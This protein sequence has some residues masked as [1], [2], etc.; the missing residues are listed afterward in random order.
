[1][2]FRIYFSTLRLVVSGFPLPPRN[3]ERRAKKEIQSRHPADPSCHVR[4][5]QP[6]FRIH[7]RGPS[8]Q[9]CKKIHL[10]ETK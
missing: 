3:T 6:S 7:K 5:R 9:L 4:G 8:R 2:L 1:M 10:E